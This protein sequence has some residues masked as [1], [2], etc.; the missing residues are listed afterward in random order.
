MTQPESFEQA[1]RDTK[2][3]R[4]EADSED[5]LAGY[6]EDDLEPPEQ[7]SPDPGDEPAGDD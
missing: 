3:V 4:R 6:Q 7:T 5:L 1:Q 2:A